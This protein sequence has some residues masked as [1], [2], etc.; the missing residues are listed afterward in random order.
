M[1]LKSDARFEEKV[2][3]GL[4]NDIEEFGKFLPEYSNVSKLGLWWGTFIQSRKLFC[5]KFTEELCIIT[6]KNDAKFEEEM[7]CLFKIDNTIWRI[8]TREF[9]CLKDLHFNGLP[10][11]KVYR[12]WDKKVQ[13]S[14]VWW[15]WRLTQNLKE[16]QLVLIWQIFTGWK[17]AISF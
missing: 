17:I 10:L 7:T 9:K 1:T 14:Y 13:K 3:Y 8:L 12:F 16:N 11:I 2:T 4:E 15:H 5:L 6:M